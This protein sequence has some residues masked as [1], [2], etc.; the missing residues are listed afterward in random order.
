MA[1]WIVGHN[2]S[3]L[4]GHTVNFPNP[5]TD[6]SALSIWLNKLRLACI[7]SRPG[8]SRGFRFR[9]TSIGT[10]AEWEPEGGGGKGGSGL[11]Y[12]GDFQDNISYQVNDLVRSR[13]G[14]Y[15]LGV[16]ICVKDNPVVPATGKS[17]GPQYPEPK[18]VTGGD[19]TWELFSLG[20]KLYT[21]CRSGVS[22]QTYINLNEV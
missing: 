21:S 5:L 18:D 1:I 22:K 15:S 11:R 8:H 10:F 17:L 6:N 12:R 13:S 3:T 7:A 19:N 14:N 20:V 4:W 2:R 16:F 9:R